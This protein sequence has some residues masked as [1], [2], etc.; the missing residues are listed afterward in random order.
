MR[1]GRRLGPFLVAWMMWLVIAAGLFQEGARI[2][3]RWYLHN[4]IGGWPQVKVSLLR[5]QITSPRGEGEWRGLRVVWE[6]AE[7]RFSG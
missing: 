3:L 6:G 4:L 7:A 5:F 1:S 2:S